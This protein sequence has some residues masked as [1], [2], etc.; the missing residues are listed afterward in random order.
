MRHTCSTCCVRTAV[1]CCYQFHAVHPSTLILSPHHCCPAPAGRF[2]M[3]L[4]PAL[5]LDGADQCCRRY[6]SACKL[7]T[8]GGGQH[9]AYRQWQGGP[10]ASNRNSNSGS[11]GQA[12]TKMPMSIL[13]QQHIASAAQRHSMWGR[14]GGKGKGEHPPSKTA[15]SNARSCQRKA[16]CSRLCMSPASQ[17]S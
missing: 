16:S 1:V 9:T 17:R 3:L 11:N 2:T 13:H 8:V 4:A 6:V 15:M 14:G 10:K 5:V 12:G 7:A